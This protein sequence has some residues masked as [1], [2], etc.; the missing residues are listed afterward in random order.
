MGKATFSG[1][2]AGAY[3][4]ISMY[5]GPGGSD[6]DFDDYIPPG[7]KVRIFGVSTFFDSGSGVLIDVGTAGDPD[8][9]FDCPALTVDDWEYHQL[10]GALI[11]KGNYD[12]EQGGDTNNE[13]RV[14]VAGTSPL[15]LHCILHTYV[16]QHTSA[17]TV[18][19][20]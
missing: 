19:G 7:M 4:P 14:T 18:E 16:L 6:M 20:V 17:L 8:G 15:R 10:N 12:F 13:L 11:T 5:L 9:I 3:Y 1:P 2:M